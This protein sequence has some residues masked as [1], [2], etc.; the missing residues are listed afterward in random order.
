MWSCTLPPGHDGPCRPGLY[1]WQWV[2][3]LLCLLLG[4]KC[5]TQE[6]VTTARDACD[7][8]YFECDRC[9]KH[10]AWPLR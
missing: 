5:G 3:R 2:N 6:R 4:H 1:G 8:H 7:L 9:G 10:S